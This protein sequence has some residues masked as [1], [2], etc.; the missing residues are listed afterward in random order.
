MPRHSTGMPSHATG[1][2]LWYC[3]V[4]RILACWFHLAWR[5]WKEGTLSSSAWWKI[6]LLDRRFFLN[7]GRQVVSLGRFF[8]H[9]FLDRLWMRR[10]IPAITC[11]SVELGQAIVPKIVRFAEVHCRFSRTAFQCHLFYQQ[12]WPEIVCTH[13]WASTFATLSTNFNYVLRHL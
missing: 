6:P 2:A 11:T 9:G 4:S 8:P 7:M 3:P 1:S 10:G 5:K 12:V 13:F